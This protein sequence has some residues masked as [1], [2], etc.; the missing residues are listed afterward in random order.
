MT[1]YPSSLFSGDRG[2]L[3]TDARVFWN[4]SRPADCMME[5]VTNT[6]LVTVT[7]LTER[8]LFFFFDT[9]TY[10]YP[11]NLPHPRT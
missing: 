6:V 10:L 1:N 7:R 8:E 3:A 2:A 11:G 5:G 9:Y 4:L